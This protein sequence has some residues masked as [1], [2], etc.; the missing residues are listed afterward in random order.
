MKLIK[1]TEITSTGKMIMLYGATGVGK[2]TSILA[3]APEPILYAQAEQRPIRPSL[4]ACGRD[5][6]LDIAQYEGWVDFLSFINTPTDHASVVVDSMSHLMNIELSR[7][8]EDEAFDA[9]SDK[10]KEVKPL[11][12]RVKLSQEGFGSLSSNMFRL[13]AALGRLATQHGKIVIVT[14]LL[15]E[16]PSWN[17]ELI[18]GPALKGREYPSNMPGFFDLIGLVETRKNAEGKILYPPKVRF[19]S[20]DETFLAKWTGV[21]KGERAEGLLDFNKILGG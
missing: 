4:D 17:K 14:A 1:K 15:D 9:K 7:E 5:V 20:P 21:K 8:L 18:A 12:S 10:D 11:T 19:E 16:K 3:T 2:T 13:T 6:N